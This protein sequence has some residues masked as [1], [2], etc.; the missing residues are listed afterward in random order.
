MRLGKREK[1]FKTSDR[2]CIDMHF[3][4]HTCGT[5]RQQA[6]NTASRRTF[7]SDSAKRRCAQARRYVA[8]VVTG[9]QSDR[10]PAGPLATEGDTQPESKVSYKLT[11]T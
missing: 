10:L 9:E 4:I 6:L 3:C 7:A 5:A 2:R 8:A 11:S 1:S